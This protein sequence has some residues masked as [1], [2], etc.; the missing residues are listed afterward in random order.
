MSE[1]RL[2]NGL[3]YLGTGNGWAG[4][5]FSSDGSVLIAAEATSGSIWTATGRFSA[6]VADLPP[7]VQQAD[8]P[9]AQPWLAVSTS[10]DG[11][12]VAAVTAG[13]NY[14][15]TGSGP[16]TAGNAQNAWTT[17]TTAGQRSWAD[18]ALSFDGQVMVAAETTGQVW[19]GTGRY[20]S[21]LTQPLD[22]AL[23]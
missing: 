3:L 20:S 10:G 17:H 11:Q 23:D 15:Y 5:S 18:V 16:F 6:N 2:L 4:L 22:L 12:T 21:S 13:N 14:I 1:L 7:W 9:G 8:A 19:V